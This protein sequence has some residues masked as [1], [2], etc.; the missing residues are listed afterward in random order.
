MQNQGEEWGVRPL[1]GHWV[2]RLRK[3]GC[4]KALWQGQRVWRREGH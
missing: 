2:S 4:A 3:G 1:R